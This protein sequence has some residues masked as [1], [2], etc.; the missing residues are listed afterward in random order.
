ML[1]L[2]LMDKSTVVFV[3]VFIKALVENL[4]LC[5][6]TSIAG[7]KSIVIL[8][9]CCNI[10]IGSLPCACNITGKRNVISKIRLQVYSGNTFQLG[11]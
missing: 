10:M 7:V 3:G 4:N 1:T 11:L 2:N 8:D 5:S 9:A 6:T